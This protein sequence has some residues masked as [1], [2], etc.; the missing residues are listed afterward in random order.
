MAAL[1]RMIQF[2]RAIRKVALR[3]FRCGAA[4][5]EVCKHPLAHESA[6]PS[7]AQLQSDFRAS[8]NLPVAGGHVNYNLSNNYIS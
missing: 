5:K 3:A 6:L 8:T 1:T 2:T 4:T 7:S